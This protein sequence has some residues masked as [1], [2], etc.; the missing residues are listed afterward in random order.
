MKHS[1]VI[2]R[3]DGGMYRGR[4]LRVSEATTERWSVLRYWGMTIRVSE[5]PVCGRKACEMPRHCPQGLVQLGLLY[6]APNPLEVSI[7][8]PTFEPRVFGVSEEAGL[9]ETVDL[10]VEA[11]ADDI[12]GERGAA[13]DRRW[14][15]DGGE[16]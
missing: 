13:Q 9:S 8:F 1:I 11:L 6:L 14:L 15:S 4:G 5:A 10:L 3:W 2:D 16:R 7:G 12:G